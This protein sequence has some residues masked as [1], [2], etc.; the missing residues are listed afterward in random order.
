MVFCLESKEYM[1]IR[2]A[3]II[4][5]RILPHFPMLVKLSQ[6]IE[7][8][9]EK[10]REEEKNKRQDLFVLASSYI[11]QLKTKSG[12]VLESEF[13]QVADKPNKQATE[14]VKPVNGS[15]TDVKEPVVEKKVKQVAAPAEKEAK[16]ERESNGKVAEPVVVLEK[17]TSKELKREEKQREKEEKEV[18][19]RK[20]DR[21]RS[22]KRRD[23]KTASPGG[24]TYY[25]TATNDRYYNSVDQYEQ[26]D[27]ERD[28][29]LSS[30]SNESNGSSNRRHESP[31]HERGR[32]MRVTIFCVG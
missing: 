22:E 2:N 25:D 14:P 26:S 32:K 4:L 19:T 6:I 18:E 21:D 31:D 15:A 27:R 30:I 20:R 3:L 8:K 9:V 7:R 24:P 13:H 10:V 5:M 1:Q 29:D 12:M 23:R 17:K 28:R 11:G 16:K